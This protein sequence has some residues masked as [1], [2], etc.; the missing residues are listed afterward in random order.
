MADVYAGNVGIVRSLRFIVAPFVLAGLSACGQSSD[1][2]VPCGRIGLG[3]A[4]AGT[5]AAHRDSPVI[6][7]SDTPRPYVVH[8]VC[9]G[10]GCRL[11]RTFLES[12]P[13]PVSHAP[14]RNGD[15][16]SQDTS[17]AGGSALVLTSTG[18][19]VVAIDL[20]GAIRSWRIDPWA[21]DPVHEVANDPIEKGEAVVLVGGLRNSD[22]I[23]VR[24]DA[25]ELG[26]IEPEG[27]TFQS[28][29]ENR[30]ELKV[31]AV[32]DRHIIG[33]ELIDGTHER[34]V[35]VP[36]TTDAPGF[37]AGPVDLATV[38][39]LSR[40]EITAGDEF[41]VLSSGEGDDAETFVFSI[42]EGAL[43]DRFLGAAVTGPTRLDAL[44]GLHASSP[45]GSHLAYRTPSGALALRE[46]QASTSCLVRSAS[47]GDHSVAGFTADA[48]LYMQAD[49]GLG[50]SHIFAFDTLSRRLTALDAD[51]RGHHLVGAPPQLADRARPWAIG[52]RDGSYAAVQDG[53]RAASL[54]LD[55]PVFVPRHDDE[56]ALWLADKYEDN[57]SVTRVGL[58]R[59]VP[60]FDGRAYEFSVADDQANVPEVFAS[61]ASDTALSPGLSR[62]N[63]GERP[64]L[65]TGTPGGWAYQCGRA[66]A[67]DAFVAAA[68]MPNS[69][70][71]SNSRDPE[72]PDPP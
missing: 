25:N 12:E 57:K 34:V 29:A 35:L 26:S 64:C 41:V 20:H 27:A 70:A 68:P 66:G 54:G 60:H 13:P 63:A 31:I 22:T 48:M 44:P 43:V 59:F 71:S 17:L 56:S 4:V 33:R 3:E 46:L 38:P 21:E 7:I 62:L 42:P 49:F 11:V 19:W 18:R 2:A 52:V 50:A 15:G 8:P 45:D 5:V 65:A 30:P 28:I 47:G 61:D 32:G 58:R 9:D 67:G 23:V 36:V 10:A 24:N 1:P 6:A 16:V 69:E 14:H 55:G 40:I 39:T 51:D 37:F 53:A 72:V